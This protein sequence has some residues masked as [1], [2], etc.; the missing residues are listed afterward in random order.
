MPDYDAETA[1]YV[2][3]EGHDREVAKEKVSSKVAKAFKQIRSHG[4]PL[5]MWL[6]PE[7]FRLWEECYVR[8]L[9]AH[10]DNYGQDT[11][12]QSLHGQV[13]LKAYAS[14]R[15]D[16]LAATMK[17]FSDTTIVDLEQAS[18][19]G[20][21]ID[22]ELVNKLKWVLK[23]RVFYKHYGL[24]AS[25]PLLSVA[26]MVDITTKFHEHELALAEVS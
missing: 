6:R 7:L 14:Y 19:D 21:N 18:E 13:W 16:V 3:L 9:A 17:F 23:K 15:E 22:K 24:L 8:H 2:Q 25:S 26:F 4:T 1:T 12:S 20:Q 5:R 10:I 11:T